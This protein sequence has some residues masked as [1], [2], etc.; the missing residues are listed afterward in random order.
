M[1]IFVLSH[2]PV[3]SARFHCYKH[4]PKMILE[5]AQMMCTASNEYCLDS[6]YKS[7]YKNH[8]C[9]VWARE[10]WDNW[11]WLFRLATTLNQHYRIRFGHDYNHK[12]YDA[13]CQIDAIK[14]HSLMPKGFT[15]HPQCMPDKYKDQNPVIAYRNYYKGEKK[16][17]AKWRLITPEWW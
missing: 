15:P 17:F 16:Y 2:S 11:D 3:W 14:L 7:A 6:P 4:V 10:S 13:I 1:N 5:T 8:P 9:T 12:S